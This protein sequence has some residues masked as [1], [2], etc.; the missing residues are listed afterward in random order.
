MFLFIHIIVQSE[1]FHEVSRWANMAVGPQS[2]DGKWVFT[3]D[4][5]LCLDSDPLRTPD[6]RWNHENGR[7]SEAGSFSDSIAMDS[8]HLAGDASTANA[9]TQPL[10]STR[11]S[12]V[13]GDINVTV[14]HGP[15]LDELKQLIVQTLSEVGATTY[16]TPHNL[17]EADRR[18]IEEHISSFDE[19]IAEGAASDPATDLLVATAANAS[20]NYRDAAQRLN[21]ILRTHPNSPEADDAIQVLAQIS[22]RMG[23]WEQAETLVG[24]AVL[25]F[26]AK[27]NWRGLGHSLIRQARIQSNNGNDQLALSTYEEAAII[28][29]RHR[30]P[31]LQTRSLANQGILHKEIGNF[32]EAKTVLGEALRISRSINDLTSASTIKKHLSEIYEIQGDLPTASRLLRESRMNSAKTDDKYS[33]AQQVL[34]E[35]K[36]LERRNNIKMAITAYQNAERMFAE[37]GA[38]DKQAEICLILAEL[39]CDDEDD[40]KAISWYEAALASLEGLARHQDRLCCLAELGNLYLMTGNFP[41]S[42]Q[43]ARQAVDS[44]IRQK[45]HQEELKSLITLG[46]AQAY[47]K[48]IFEARKTLNAANHLASSCGISDDRQVRLAAMLASNQ[49]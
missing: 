36:V 31:T 27:G 7:F 6:G 43:F 37:I 44:S 41:K 45:N 18:L 35:A 20:G 13:M 4:G 24:Q 34:S 25:K 16:H 23:D 5:W 26:E 19:L 1:G 11:D 12:V 3:A 21:A 10:I 30:I 2:P 38:N 46:F 14:N 33:Q 29:Q 8:V 42:I 32:E 28:G 17:T 48:E 49:R 15:S 9:S 40:K 39:A 47:N 22:L